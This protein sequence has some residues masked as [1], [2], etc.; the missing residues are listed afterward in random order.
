MKLWPHLRFIIAYESSI[1]KT[2]KRKNLA[3]LTSILYDK[4]DRIKTNDFFFGF[5]CCERQHLLWFLGNNFLSFFLN[6]FPKKEEE[7]SNYRL[8]TELIFKCISFRSEVVFNTAF[9]TFFMKTTHSFVFKLFCSCWHHMKV[10]R[11][12]FLD[13]DQQNNNVKLKK[14]NK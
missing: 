14:K 1:I 3:I 5:A 10:N 13:Y 7:I 8:N 2:N 11:I 12:F 9:S 6:T 4:F